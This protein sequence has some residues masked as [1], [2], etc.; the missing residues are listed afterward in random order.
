MNPP[1]PKSAAKILHDARWIA[2]LSQAQ[3]AKRAGI[4]QQT[5]A[6]Y[7]RG[8]REPSVPTLTRLVAG[9]GLELTWRLMPA[10][11][12]EDQTTLAL[13]ELP[14][15]ERLR[16]DLAR[17]L[18]RLVRGWRGVDM[19]IGGKTGARLLGADV[20]VFEL[21]VWV[22]DRTDLDVLGDCLDRAEVVY[23]SPSGHTGPAEVTREQ[24]VRGW[25]LVSPKADL[26]LRSVPS[27]SSIRHRASV[28]ELPGE[29]FSFLVASPDDCPMWWGDRESD[30][31][32]LQRVVRLGSQGL[33]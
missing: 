33:A 17:A 5:V 10:P 7:E 11:G 29:P 13:L 32:A 22:D 6:K 16:S 30:H 12:F 9:C 20:R 23:I 4:T 3:V 31:L 27:F 26:R 15:L 2:C 24:L 21:E 28:V 18:A 8:L 25:P 19:I 14:P 1:P